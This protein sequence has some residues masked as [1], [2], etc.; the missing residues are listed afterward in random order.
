MIIGH[1]ELL[2]YFLN[3][4]IIENPIHEKNGSPSYGLGEAGYDLRINSLQEVKTLAPT[5]DLGDPESLKSVALTPTIE[6]EEGDW[7]IE[8]NRVYLGASREKFKMPSDVMGICF[9][10]SSLARVGLVTLCTPL[11]PG[12]DGY[13]TVE[14]INHG[15][16]TIILPKNSGVLQVV[17][18]QVLGASQYDGKYQN[19]K[20]NP[21]VTLY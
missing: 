9:S 20:D 2:K 19:Q 15:P 10:K 8:P 4:E 12:W 13:L 17:F 21:Q 14:L 1:H 16:S 5:I 11:E 6:T 3:G 18:H 7:V